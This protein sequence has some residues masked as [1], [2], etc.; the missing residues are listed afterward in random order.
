MTDSTVQP[1]SAAAAPISS[2]AAHN[3]ESSAS[4]TLLASSTAPASSTASVAS[5][6]STAQG[7]PDKYEFKMPANVKDDPA[8]K[9]RIET[10]ARSRGLSNE[11]G[12][13]LLDTVITEM[14]AQDTARTAAWEPQTGE[15]WKQRDTEWRTS[16]LA[17][18]EI[19]GSQEKL[20]ASVELAKK[21]V[22]KFGGDDV[23]AF[24]ETTGLGSHPAA[25]K[26][27]A[28][29]GKAMSESTLIVGSPGAGPEKKSA[30]E[31]MYGPTG[32]GK[33]Q[34]T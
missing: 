16:A 32:T 20:A 34:N 18:T 5:T 21:A 33:T 28:R 3:L 27:L 7:A 26:L 22:A 19:G 15:A 4:A 31:R 14:Q 29:I 17:D 25:I 9:Q 13:Q 6:A 11:A 24:L 2:A 1:S 30:A 12:Q 8:L 23:T 10:I